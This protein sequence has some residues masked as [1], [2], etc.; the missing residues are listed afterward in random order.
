MAF[1][2]NA[3][4]ISSEIVGYT[5]KEM[6]VGGATMSG[7]S[8]VGIGET[9]GLRLTALE[10]K[11]YEA[12]Q[13]LI[14]GEGTTGEFNIQLL[15][16]LGKTDKT[17]LWVR[18]YDADE[19]KWQ[20]DGC[21]MYNGAAITA[22]DENDV[23]F[24][25]GQGLWISAPD[26]TD[27]DGAA[28]TFT[29]AGAVSTNDVKWV[30]NIGGATACA[31]PYP[32][33]IRLSSLIPVGYESNQDLIDGEGTTGEFNIQI[34]TKVGKTEKTYLW[35]RSYDAD[36]ETWVDDGHWVYN[37]ATIVA[38]SEND[39]EFKAGQGLWIVAPDYTDDDGAE[40][41]MT[42]RYPAAN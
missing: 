4:A 37:G 8:F 29:D 26:Y 3:G 31:N 28:Y 39:P 23:L 2:G 15:T 36:G 9:T 11:G 17:Y 6:N 40:Y 21:W 30:F 35:V 1:Q 42:A 5:T 13:D 41:S 20:N 25:A 12:N 10:P 27:D 16:K 24:T 19:E 32:T 34:L 18:T 38:G 14:D 22:G 7:N 33:S